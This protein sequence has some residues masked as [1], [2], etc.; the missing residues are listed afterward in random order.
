MLKAAACAGAFLVCVLTL[1]TTVNQTYAQPAKTRE[2]LHYHHD[3]ESTFHK[4]GRCINHQHQYGHRHGD[5][6]GEPPLIAKHP[7]TE[8]HMN[9]ALWETRADPDKLSSAVARLEQH[10]CYHAHHVGYWNGSIYHDGGDY[11]DGHEGCQHRHRHYYWHADAITF[12]HPEDSFAA[13]GGSDDWG[14]IYDGTQ[15]RWH[16]RD[17]HDWWHNSG[18]L[19]SIFHTKT[20]CTGS[21]TGTHTH[22]GEATHHGCVTELHSYTHN[23]LGSR[24]HSHRWHKSNLARRHPHCLHRH[25]DSKIG[26]KKCLPHPG[27]SYIHNTIPWPRD[28]SSIPADINVMHAS[29]ISNHSCIHIHIIEMPHDMCLSHPHTYPHRGQGDADHPHD[30]EAIHNPTNNPLLRSHNNRWLHKCHHV[31]NNHSHVHRDG[32][33]LEHPH[34]YTHY[35]TNTHD[36]V[37]AH[38][39]PPD[40]HREA[41][42][43]SYC[44]HSH[45]V[46]HDHNRK[47][48]QHPHTYTHSGDPAISEHPDLDIHLAS[49]TSSDHE[50]EQPAQS[51]PH[52]YLYLT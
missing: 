7:D 19:D 46:E 42:N 32:G 26:H 6:D 44:P 13:H 16:N 30:L 11:H 21:E 33:C 48:K 49:G 31:H 9:T 35:G 37:Y 41:N 8:I 20:E 4:H 52:E 39:P 18:A 36:G 24:I 15:H 23:G 47:C 51:S 29:R 27:H 43:P 10:K 45:T 17:T 28:H 22:A 34:S 5:I 40:L 14:W 12:S 2:V 25:I 50:C 1:Q 38:G 3:E